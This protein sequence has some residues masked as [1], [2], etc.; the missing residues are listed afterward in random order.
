MVSIEVS[1]GSEV[2]P[3][4]V[5]ELYRSHVPE[6]VRLAYLLTGDADA[7]QDIAHDAF[8]RTTG[9]LRHLQHPDA[10]AAY[11]RR[12]VVNAATSHHRRRNVELRYLWRESSRRGTE[13]ASLPDLEERDELRALLEALPIRQR[14]AVVLRYYED[15][16]E[17]QLADALR[18]S[19]PAAR[20]LLSRGLQTLRSRF[21][22]AN[23]DRS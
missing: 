20:S 8:V 11:L 15:L 4:R 3:G 12:A 19:V 6:A 1:S 2:R 22:E 5:E 10:Y 23:D 16:S 13:T 21:E 18:C 14:T 7:A 17:Q 9:R